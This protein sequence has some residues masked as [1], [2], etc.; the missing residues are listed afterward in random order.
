MEEGASNSDLEQTVKSQMS[1]D[2]QG[3]LMAFQ[4]LHMRCQQNI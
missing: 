4:H 3:A 1:K 2:G